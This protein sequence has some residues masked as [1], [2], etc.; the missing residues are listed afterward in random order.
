MKQV[1]LGSAALLLLAGA[2]HAADMPVKA[3]PV[4]A[5]PPVAY[6]WTGFYVGGYY[7]DAIGETRARSSITPG[8]AQVNQKSLT[9][10]VT[11]GFNWQFDPRFLVGVEADLGGTTLN[12][13]EQDWDD[14]ILVG[15][16]L[17]WYGTARGRIGYVT[18]PSLLYVTGGAAFL[19]LTEVFGGN[20]AGVLAPATSF[21][22]T[23]VGWTA[24]GGIETKLSHNWSAKTEYLYIDPTN[25]FTAN[26]FGV[27]Q[28]A[29]F[30][31]RFHVIKTGLNYQFGPGPND[32]ILSLF[33]APPLPSNHNWGGVYVGLNAGLGISNAHGPGGEGAV[34]YNTETDMNGTG[35]AGGGQIGY[36]YM[37]T[38]KWFVG[39]EGD[40]GALAINSSLAEWNDTGRFFSER[41]RW[42]GTARA[43]FGT[44]TGPALLYLTGGGAW[45]HLTDGIS[46]TGAG[47][48]VRSQTPG[49]WT[50]G[51][52]TEVA[53]D[54]R[55]SATFETLY[56]DVGHTN[57][58]VGAVNA[59]FKERFTVVRAGLNLKLFD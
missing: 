9:G 49:G 18:G 14:T 29:N 13:T 8:T 27:P 31:N 56:I 36:N 50:V 22:T 20:A 5:P 3:M 16:K 51:G 33:T 42:Y 28:I 38:R 17:D 41:T 44:S 34:P 52:G 6:D 7:G 15:T 48:D 46:I 19:H 10:G 4:K 39:V 25:S 2:V 53:L 43:R 24:G 47:T 59:D 30:E 45:V 32:G 11:A 21:S 37:I 1:L 12:R 58:A 55:W 40:L 54:Q 26:V 35:V 57:H 23:K